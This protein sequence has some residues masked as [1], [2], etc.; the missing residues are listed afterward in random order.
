MTNPIQAIFNDAK[1]TIVFIVIAILA[2]FILGTR[3]V[4]FG[5]QE[6][7]NRLIESLGWGVLLI[8]AIPPV[9]VIVAIIIWFI[10]RSEPV[11][12]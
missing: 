7:T 3:G 12:F 8:L 11:G 6:F 9:G 10:K 5:M 1:E 4:A 2:I